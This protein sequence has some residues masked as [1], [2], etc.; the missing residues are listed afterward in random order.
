M[1]EARVPPPNSRSVAPD[2]GPQAIELRGTIRR[3]DVEFVCARATRTLDAR[4]PGPVACRLHDLANPAMPA[5]ETLARLA[6]RAHRNRQRMRLEH[7]P[8][9][10]VELLAFCGL[11]RIADRVDD[12]PGAASVEVRR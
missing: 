4:P 2:E 7:A 12:A 1:D 3:A 8:P 6:L 11:N 5:V 9:Q 10:L